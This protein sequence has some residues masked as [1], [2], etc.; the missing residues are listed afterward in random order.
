MYYSTFQHGT[1]GVWPLA[2]EGTAERHL[3]RAMEYSTETGSHKRQQEIM[4][5]RG[6]CLLGSMMLKRQMDLN[7]TLRN[8][9]PIKMH[10]RDINQSSGAEHKSTKEMLQLL[11]Y[12]IRKRIILISN[13]L[14]LSLLSVIKKIQLVRLLGYSTM[15]SMK[16]VGQNI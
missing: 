10:S 1:S 11:D 2:R 4:Q 3:S 7:S 5:I 16:R 8:F 15:I 12:M 13:T 9:H 6:N 14:I